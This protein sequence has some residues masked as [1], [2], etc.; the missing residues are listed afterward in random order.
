MKCIISLFHF[1]HYLILKEKKEKEEKEKEWKEKKR[2]GGKR[3]K[4]LYIITFK[5]FNGFRFSKIIQVCLVNEISN[6]TLNIMLKIS[7]QE[8]I[9]NAKFIKINK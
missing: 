4:N 8:S 6:I 5:S 9:D 2:K 7:F 3:K 1:L